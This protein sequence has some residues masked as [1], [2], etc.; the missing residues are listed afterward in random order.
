MHPE[1]RHQ[2]RIAVRGAPR[3]IVQRPPSRQRGPNRRALLAIVDV[4]SA[5]LTPE[6]GPAPDVALEAIVD[7][8]SAEI[9]RQE[10]VLA[11]RRAEETRTATPAALTSDPEEEQRFH[12]W[13]VASERIVKAHKDASGWEDAPAHVFGRFVERLR[14]RHQAEPPTETEP[15][16]PAP[17]EAQILPLGIWDPVPEGRR[18]RR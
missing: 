11:E 12:R 15:I 7:L 9:E 10:Q 13:L 8:A 18:I 1:P 2:E 14:R 5:G 6:D 3:R 16:G 4:A 17:D